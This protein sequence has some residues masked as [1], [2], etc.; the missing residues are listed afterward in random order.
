MLKSRETSISLIEKLFLCCIVFSAGSQLDYSFSIVSY[1]MLALFSVLMINKKIAIT[2]TNLIF[3][4]GLIIASFIWVLQTNK[5]SNSGSLV[6]IIKYFFIISMPIIYITSPS[7]D[8]KGSLN[9]VVKTIIGFSVLSNILYVFI[10]LGVLPTTQIKPYCDTFLYLEL[11]FRDP[12]YGIVGGLRN[13]GIYWEPG[14]YQVYLNFALLFALYAVDELPVGKK[15][16]LIIYLATTI[17][18]TGSITGILLCAIL[19]AVY[20]ILGSKRFAV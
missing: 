3:I 18:T 10:L 15:I 8:K 11:V 16:A 17:M 4:L 2:K 19:I 7:V 9:F 12:V 6:P 5:Y 14:M 13:S 20:I 1:A